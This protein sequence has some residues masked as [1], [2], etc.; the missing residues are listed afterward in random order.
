[1]T[2]ASVGAA[3]GAIV[4]AHTGPFAPIAQWALAAGAL[5]VSLE[6]PPGL[7]DKLARSLEPALKATDSDWSNAAFWILLAMTGVQ[8]LRGQ[9][10]APAVTLAWY[11]ANALL[12]GRRSPAPRPNAVERAAA[13][14]KNDWEESP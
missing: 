3:T 9:I 14:K 11:A 5:D 7:A 13:T 4:I 8:L 10:M 1:M 2:S 12:M 6:A